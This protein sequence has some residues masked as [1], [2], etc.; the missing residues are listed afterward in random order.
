[1]YNAK[2]NSVIDLYTDQWSGSYRA[3]KWSP[4]TKLINSASEYSGWMV[5]T[6]IMGQCIRMISVHEQRDTVGSRSLVAGWH[7]HAQEK[8]WK[9][10]TSK[11]VSKNISSSR[12]WVIDL[13][14]GWQ[15][16]LFDKFSIVHNLLDFLT[17]KS[18]NVF[19]NVTTVAKTKRKR[20]LFLD[21]MFFIIKKNQWNPKT[22]CFVCIR[23]NVS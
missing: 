2:Q 23:Y 11:S 4:L 10:G 1:M 12:S 6:R 19:W 13:I 20:K 14:I 8:R 5:I 16:K 15:E 3:I 17:I 22:K 21:Y 7:N 18:C 9:F